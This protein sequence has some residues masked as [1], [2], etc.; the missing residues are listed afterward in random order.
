MKIKIISEPENNR[1]YTG[2]VG[3]VVDHIPY[4]DDEEFYGCRD[5]DGYINFVVKKDGILFTE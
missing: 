2:K 4:Y 3:V 1:W 5:E